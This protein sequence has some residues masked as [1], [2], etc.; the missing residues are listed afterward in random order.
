MFC[1]FFFKQ[2]TAYEMRIS[3]W[4]SDV[5]SSDLIAAFVLGEIGQGVAPLPAQVAQRILD[6]DISVPS[7][8]RSDDSSRRKRP[9]RLCDIGADL[10]HVPHDE[11]IFI[12]VNGEARTDD[13]ISEAPAVRRSR[14]APRRAAERA[15]DRS[16]RKSTRL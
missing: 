5:C 16:D 13:D 8:D 15:V 7:E 1:F 12:A 3:D 9:L 4:I 6:P 2:K 10:R 11:L 14:K